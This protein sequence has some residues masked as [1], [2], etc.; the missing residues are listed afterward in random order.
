MDKKSISLEVLQRLLAQIQE[1]RRTES[2]ETSSE[3]M[4]PPAFHIVDTTEQSIGK[5]L[6]ITGAKKPPE[7]STQ[8]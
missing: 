7:K 8:D 6:I 3:A 2:S 1:K 5:S 4:K